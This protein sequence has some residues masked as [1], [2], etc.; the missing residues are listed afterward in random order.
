MSRASAR[1][2]MVPVGLVVDVVD[3]SFLVTAQR[4]VEIFFLHEYAR[5][6]I[7]P[8]I[9]RRRFELHGYNP[10]YGTHT[11]GGDRS[12]K[13]Q[14]GRLLS[15]KIQGQVTCRIMSS[16]LLPALAQRAA[17]SLMVSVTSAWEGCAWLKITTFRCFQVVQVARMISEFVPLRGLA[18]VAQVC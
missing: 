9:D 13:E 16:P 1:R 7:I 14:K 4:F 12:A 17:S 8:L 10:Y 18:G 5:L 3:A 2:S 6:R 15:L 11:N